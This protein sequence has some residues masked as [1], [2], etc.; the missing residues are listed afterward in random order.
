MKSFM[1]SHRFSRGIQ[2][3]AIAAVVLGIAW[4][5]GVVSAQNVPDHL[6]PVLQP[7]QNPF[8]KVDVFITFQDIPGPREVNLIRVGG[9]HVKY[10]YWLVPAIAARMPIG[11][12]SVLESFSQVVRIERV[13]KVYAI[14][15]ELDDAW[16]VKRIGAGIVHEYNKGTGVKVGIIDSGI[17][18]THPDLN[19]NYA[20]GYDFINND[21][22]PMDE[23]GHGTHVAGTV[24]AED[25]DF[26]V[27]GVA[28][29]ACLY[30]LSVFP[31]SGGGTYD[32]VI[33]ALEW[34]LD[35]NNDGDTSDH[36]EVTNNSYGSSGD[37]GE[38]VEEAFVNAY[39]AGVLHVAAA[40]NAGAGEDT[41]LYPAK[42]D[43]VVAVAATDSSDNRASFSSTGPAVE[44][45]APGVGILSTIY[46]YRDRGPLWKNYGTASGTSMASPHVAGT[47]AL[48]KAA[49]PDMTNDEVRQLLIDT[50]DDLGDLGRDPQYG[51]GLVDAVEA[52]GVPTP[53]PTPPETPEPEPTPRPKPTK[54]PK[55]TP[56]GR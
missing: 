34:C 19:D 53:T 16:G 2:V 10:A 5:A 36:M 25:N 9:G 47:V 3:V 4:S 7:G 11:G 45:A 8:E 42:Y 21:D 40:G 26:G 14:D 24:A 29:E 56:R 13:L 44:L 33:A 31:K 27:V 20:G 52:V 30:A 37:P 41:V 46:P 15:A 12:V 35:P 49:N 6:R 54:K 48:V 55:P 43:S 1:G 18:Y 39:V 38:T 23:H 32:D 51:F 50:A 28:P 22:D 17:D